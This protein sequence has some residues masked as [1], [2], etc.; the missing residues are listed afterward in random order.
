[1]REPLFI[2]ICSLSLCICFVHRPAQSDFDLLCS[3]V[4]HDFV[5]LATGLS[6]DTAVIGR[7]YDCDRHLIGFPAD[8]QSPWTD[9]LL[10]IAANCFWLILWCLLLV[11]VGFVIWLVYKL[12]LT[13]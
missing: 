11:L 1:M 7:T 6:T 5:D 12:I 3:Q 10:K 9:T 13:V 2:H 8:G 4:Q